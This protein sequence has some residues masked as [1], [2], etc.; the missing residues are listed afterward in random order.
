MASYLSLLIVNTMVS[1]RSILCKSFCG[2]FVGIRWTLSL[3]SDLSL[4]IHESHLSFFDILYAWLL[5]TSYFFSDIWVSFANLI[6]LSC[7]VKRCFVM[8]SILRCPFPVT[9]GAARHACIVAIKNKKMGSI[10][11]W[12][13]LVYIMSSFLL[14]YSVF[15]GT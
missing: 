7:N 12:M 9:E 15:P 14:H 6:Y 2:V 10:P 8:A 1:W 5:I 4:F 11:T 3:W 13:D